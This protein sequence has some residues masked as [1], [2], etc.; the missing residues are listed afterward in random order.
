MPLVLLAATL[1][2]HSTAPPPPNNYDAGSSSREISQAAP[3]VSRDGSGRARSN[4]TKAPFVGGRAAVK[5]PP[6]PPPP[7]RASAS[8]SR[9]PP[10]VQAYFPRASTLLVSG[11]SIC[12]A[13]PSSRCV[14]QPDRGCCYVHSPMPHDISG[15]K[16]DERPSDLRG[17]QG[18]ERA[19]AGLPQAKQ[20]KMVHSR[21]YQCA[22]GT[23]EDVRFR[24]TSFVTV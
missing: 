16:S 23:T 20:Y 1:L 13:W 9:K 12:S 2:A 7:L 10:R 5:K 8:R 19:R 24:G 18:E 15:L 21:R 14:R 4:A 17:R 11:A 22:E 6:P 3:A